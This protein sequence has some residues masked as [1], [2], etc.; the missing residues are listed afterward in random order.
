MDIINEMNNS[1]QVIWCFPLITWMQWFWTLPAPFCIGLMLHW[2]QQLGQCQQTI[3]LHIYK[4]IVQDWKYVII[5]CEI[6]V[7]F[8]Y[9]QSAENIPWICPA[10]NE[11]FQMFW[12]LLK[13]WHVP[14]SS[15]D[16]HSQVHLAHAQSWQYVKNWLLWNN[17][18]IMLV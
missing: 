12:V 11:R 16:W 8:W 18:E 15:D 14:F 4:V 3:K 9:L 10:L 2:L 1:F 7:S 6:G 5:I 13:V 17:L